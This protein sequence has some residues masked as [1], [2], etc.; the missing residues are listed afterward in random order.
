MDAFA[1]ARITLM[2]S[3]PAPTDIEI[4]TEMISNHSEP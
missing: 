1:L 4:S 3:R 2:I